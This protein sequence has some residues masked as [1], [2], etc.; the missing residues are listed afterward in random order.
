MF[1]VKVSA[2]VLLSIWKRINY[3]A[4]HKPE[5][6][7]DQTGLSKIEEKQTTTVWTLQT[8]DD[9]SPQK[10]LF[11]EFM[12]HTSTCIKSSLDEFMYHTSTCIKSSQ[13]LKNVTDF[14]DEPS[15]PFSINPSC[16][17]H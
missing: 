13:C 10:N 4:L 11:D 3:V 9:S 7:H 14:L 16:N 5:Q 17:F 15:I 6:K 8:F 2:L 12:Y 1:K